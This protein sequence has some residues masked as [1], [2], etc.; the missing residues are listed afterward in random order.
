LTQKETFQPGTGR[1][2][3]EAGSFQDAETPV[4]LK[5]KRSA[6]VLVYCTTSLSN[7]V[8]VSHS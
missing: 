4:A 6:A 3:E 8:K 2:Q 7:N 5:I 1:H